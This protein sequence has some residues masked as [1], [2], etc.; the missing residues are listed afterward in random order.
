MGASIFV[1]ILRGLLLAT[2]YYRSTEAFY[3]VISIYQDVGWGWALRLLHSTVAS[4]VFFFVYL[5]LGR[6]LY[7][8]SYTKTGVWVLGVGIYLLLIGVA[9][10]GYVLPMGQMSYWAATVITNL[11]SALPFGDLLVQWVWGGFAV[12]SPTLA[13]F[14]MLHFLLP[15]VI[16][17]LL[18]FH[19]FYLHRA[20]SSNPI[21]INSNSIKVQFHYFYS[22]KD[23]FGFV[24]FLALACLVA[25]V[26]GY[27]P[28]IDR[29]NFI[30]A[31]ALVTPA[32][33]QP[34]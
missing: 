18:L 14:Y 28:L 22:A 24:W 3:S 31:R 9:F 8:R 21:G 7:F 13:R 5:H 16:M 12:S 19:I 10:L 20:G 15:F 32:H 17:G 30:A 2:R 34:E 26:W 25:G 6:G 11:L 4:F 33:I 29:E 23:L 1:Q 27:S